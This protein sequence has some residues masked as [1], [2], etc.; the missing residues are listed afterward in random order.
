VL[1]KEDNDLVKKCME[2]EVEGFR[3]TGR[4]KRTWREVVLKHDAFI[5]VLMCVGSES[6]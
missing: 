1:R 6:I 4:P 5:C 2:Y 3:P